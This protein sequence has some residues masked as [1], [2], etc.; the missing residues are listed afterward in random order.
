MICRFPVTLVVLLAV[1]ALVSC[2]SSPTLSSISITP[3]SATV[4]AAGDTVQFTA[5]GTYTQGAHPSSTRDITSSVTWASTT[6]AIATI[7]ASGLAT[8]VSSGTTSVTATST[9]SSGPVVGTASLTVTSGSVGMGHQLTS[10]SIIPGAQTLNAVGATAQFIAIGT[11]SSSP[12]TQNMAGLVTWQSSAVDIASVNSSGQA[13]AVGCASSSCQ[14][15]ITASATAQ[16]GSLITGSAALTVSPGSATATRTLAA[17]TIIPG[18]GTQTLES[19]N[20][21]AQFL[22]IG[23][24]TA[25]PTTQDLTDQVTWVSSDTSIA[26]IDSTGLATSVRC[27]SSGCVTTITAS[28]TSGMGAYIFATSNLTVNPGSGGSGLPSLAVYT[29]GSGTGTVVSSPAGVNCVAGEGC[30]GYFTSGSTVELTAT[31]TAGSTFGGWSANCQPDTQ[32][33][34]KVTMSGNQTVGAI[35]N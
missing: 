28:A 2:S 25:N 34:C 14:T 12:T 11:F 22:A 30:S 10:L 23:T 33:T 4:P 8:G 29:V 5:M 24:F 18:T 9:T 3:N 27:A 1:A 16:D 19:L 26:T 21:T 13:T 7:N 32:T 20:E 15:T 31:P 35:F 17:I 6:P